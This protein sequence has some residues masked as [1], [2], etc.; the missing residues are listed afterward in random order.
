MAHYHK[1]RGQQSKKW[2]RFKT[3]YGMSPSEWRALKK[4]DPAQAHQVRMKAEAIYRKTLKSVK[5]KDL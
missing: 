2:E 1:A 3:R 5:A 4:S